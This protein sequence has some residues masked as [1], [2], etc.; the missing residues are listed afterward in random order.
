M[1]AFHVLHVIGGSEFGGIVPHV[2][3]LVRMARSR[4][5]DASVLATN[6]RIVSYYRAR[7]IEVV[8]IPG[9]DR[10]INPFRDML[11]LLRL[12]RHLR[13]RRYTVVHTHTSKGGIIGR[14]AA[15][16]TEVPMTIHTSQGYAFADYAKGA[17]SRSLFLQAERLATGWCDFIITVNEN[18]RLKALEHGIVDPSK[19]V[20]I[21]NGISLEEADAELAQDIGPVLEELRLDPKR[22]IVGVL[23][24]LAP[25][26]G[27]RFFLEA[28]P[29]IVRRFPE[30]QFLVVGSGELEDELRLEASR[31]N[32]ADRVRFA[33]FRSDSFRLLRAMNVL[34]MPS[35]WEG[36]PITLLEA[37]A[38]SLPIVATRI[39]GITD[40]CEGADAVLL[41]E[42][43][44]STAIAVAVARFLADPEEAKRLGRAARAHI[45]KRFSDRDMTQ[46]T[47]AVYEAVARKKGIALH[48]R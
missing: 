9:I 16:L 47:W 27:V 40:V 45:E 24:R 5:G 10:P 44:N 23:G 4:G 13:R 2:A 26:K 11:G 3:S 14:L 38:A 29:A 17:I 48:G 18:D 42:P 46:R 35:L 37:M 8:Q 19:I 33:G 22:P 21:L 20:T 31:L 41:V 30:A 6:P 25:Q 12:L 36:L 39:K 34:V 15:R 43:A 28:I 1:T 7:N 32:V